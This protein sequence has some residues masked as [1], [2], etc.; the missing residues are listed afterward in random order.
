MGFLEIALIA[1]TF[2]CSIVAGLVFA[3]AV[4]VMPG[5]KTLPDRDFIRAFQVIDQVIQNNQPVFMLAWVGSA[6]SLLVTAGFGIAQLT[7][8][9]R[10]MLILATAIYILAVQIPT[11][12]I[13]I[14]LNNRLQT[15][16]VENMSEEALKTARSDFEPRWNRWNT[17]RT[18][19]ACLV[20]IILLSLLVQL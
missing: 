8:S 5:I 15:L 14:P 11:I 9:A 12:T 4:V 19:F 3:F 13:N 7:G 1:A 20:T 16:D 10:V 18:V 6:L 2:L 17:I